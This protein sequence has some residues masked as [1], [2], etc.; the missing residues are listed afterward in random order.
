MVSTFSLQVI[1]FGSLHPHFTYCPLTFLMVDIA[2]LDGILRICIVCCSA[3]SFIKVTMHI[4]PDVSPFVRSRTTRLDW[5]E[6]STCRTTTIHHTVLQ[7]GNCLWGDITQAEQD[8][9]FK[10]T[11]AGLL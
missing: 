2:V 3:R 4:A 1:G 6:W 7:M 5:P 10:I 9:F 8:I 11:V